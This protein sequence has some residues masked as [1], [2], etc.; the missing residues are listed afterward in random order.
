MQTFSDKVKSGGIKY[1]QSCAKSQQT[2]Q[3]RALLILFG[4]RLD[5]FF[6]S[7]APL[8]KK[9]SDLRLSRLV[10]FCN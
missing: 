7:V 1:L 10:L 2:K 3:T 4:R 8:K 6:K 9:V 5:F